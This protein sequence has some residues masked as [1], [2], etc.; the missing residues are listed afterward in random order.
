MKKLY[1][2]FVLF[3]MTEAG[4]G[5]D[6]ENNTQQSKLLFDHFIFGSVLLKSGKRE[7]IALNYN[8]SDQQIIFFRNGN[9]LILDEL[10]KVDT[11]YIKDKKFVPLHTFFFEVLLQNKQAD[12]LATYTNVKKTIPNG[13]ANN[14]A[15]DALNPVFT[16]TTN[17]YIGETSKKEIVEIKKV[18]WINKKETQTQINNPKQLLQL[19]T[20]EKK[21]IKKYIRKNSPDITDEESV[22]KIYGFCLQISI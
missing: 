10:E 7:E 12:L 3:L 1:F 15:Q 2:F 20:K 16:T 8:T 11:V 22:K 14:L 17:S 5:Q 9:Y 6:V 18:F 13:Y 21:A 4:Y 19:F